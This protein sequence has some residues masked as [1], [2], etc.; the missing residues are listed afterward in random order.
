VKGLRDK[1]WHKETGRE[2]K[3]KELARKC[4]FKTFFSKL[5]RDS[6]MISLKLFIIFGPKSLKVCK[7]RRKRVNDAVQVEKFVVAVILG[8]N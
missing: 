3:L 7:T 2:K 5:F 4:K 6:K 8:Q 1:I